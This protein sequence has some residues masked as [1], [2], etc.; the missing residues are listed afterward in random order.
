MAIIA[1]VVTVSQYGFGQKRHTPIRSEPFIY[2][3]SL[4]LAPGLALYD[5]KTSKY[6]SN[7]GV[8]S[9]D[10]FLILPQFSFGIGFNAVVHL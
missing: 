10:I 9:L 8:V 3:T 5:S 7:P 2:G 6:I 1:S 4:K